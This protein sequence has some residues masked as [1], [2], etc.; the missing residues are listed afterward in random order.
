MLHVYKYAR[1]MYARTAMRT[2]GLHLLVAVVIGFVFVF[3]SRLT[4]VSAMNLGFAA[5]IAVWVPNVIFLL[6]G[7]WLFSRAQK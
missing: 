1:S 2:Y 6:V 5:W 4:A 7:L 3:V